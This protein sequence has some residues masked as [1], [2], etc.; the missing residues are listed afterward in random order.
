[1]IPAATTSIIGRE[2]EMLYARSLLRRH[3]VR[4]VTLTGPGGVGKTTLALGIARVVASEYADGAHFIPIASIA[5]PE[6]VLPAIASTLGL[7]GDA[8]PETLGEEIGER[9]LLLILDN[10]EQVA[11]AAPLISALLRAAPGIQVMI[12]SRSLL[13]VSGEHHVQVVPLAA[14]ALSRL[15]AL[16]ELRSIPAVELFVTRAAA[17]TGTFTLTEENASLVA[18]ACSRL[19]GLPLAIELAA[20][21]LR[22]LPLSALVERL[23][24]PLDLLVDGP[25]D[26]PARLRTLRDGLAWSYSLLSP[27]EQRLFRRLAVFSGGFSLELAEQIANHDRIF[28]HGILGGIASLVD[29]NLIVPTPSDGSPRYGMLE[30][31]R[32]YAEEQ[33]GASDEHDLITRRHL[34]AFLSL[35]ED[36]NAAMEGPESSVWAHR[37]HTEQ[38]NLRVAIQRALALNEGERALRLAMELWNYWTSYNAT[39]EGRRWLEQ[40]VAMTSGEP[41]RLRARAVSILGNLALSVFDLGAA[42]QYY[43]E[44]MALWQ[45][46][47]TDDDVAFAE[48]G[49]GAVKRYQG[50]LDEALAHLQRVHAVWSASNDRPGVAI[51]EHATAALLADAG[52]IPESLERH[53]RALN[54]RREVGEPYAIGYTLVSAAIADRWAGNT[55]AALSAASEAL[56]LFESLEHSQGSVLALLLLASLAADDK[57]DSEALE[58]LRKAFAAPPGSLSVNATVE[59]LELTAALLVRRGMARPAAVLLSAATSHRQTRGLV[60]P[61]PERIPVADTR[62]TIAQALGVTA[63]STAWGEG[64]RLSLEQ[65]IDSAIIAIADPAWAASGGAMYD[66]T[67]RELEVLSLLAEHLSD[68]EIAD[69]LF[70][71]PRTIE[72]HVSNILLKMEAPNRR[73]AAA[74]AVRERLVATSH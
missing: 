28:D 17:A 64:Q 42:Q 19:D 6:L 68:R 46:I 10:F 36:A 9:D 20:A 44:A 11:D 35:A 66:L 39:V 61:I 41:T 18:Q 54:L 43:L 67:R 58:L 55:V 33:L 31:I 47:G 12:T 56:D 52:R 59:A 5:D 22:H 49:L 70:L 29:S 57:R 3:D 14:P 48:L 16:P 40:A 60:V 23:A 45:A 27:D 53:A 71:S 1:M 21:R 73:I 51:A 34:D 38:A 7:R 72:R 26:A 50:N 62:A 32:E 65:A 69:R 25:R 4:L 30:T 13:R 15:P 37:I 63:F 24:H 2:A 74:R 8:T